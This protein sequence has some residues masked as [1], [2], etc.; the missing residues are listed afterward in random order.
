MSASPGTAD[1]TRNKPAF[2]SACAAVANVVY[3][4]GSIMGGWLTV[5]YSTAILSLLIMGLIAGLAVL[6][7]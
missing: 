7:R 5:T 3:A 1:E 4:S 2:V 6:F